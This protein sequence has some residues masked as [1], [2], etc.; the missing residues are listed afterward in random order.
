MAKV[1][2]DAL[3]LAWLH[4]RRRFEAQAG[5]SV[6]ASDRRELR[7]LTMEQLAVVGRTP[8]EGLER[9]QARSVYGLPESRFEPVCEQMI[10]IGLLCLEPAQGGP[11]ARLRL[12]ERGLRTRSTLDA[13][14]KATLVA[15]INAVGPELSARMLSALGQAFPEPG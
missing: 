1:D 6:P 2:P 7:D 10:E 14:Q 3:A 8:L 11:G 9:D 5:R 4:A 15:M 12:S 13:M